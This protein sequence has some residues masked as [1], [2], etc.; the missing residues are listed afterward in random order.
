MRDLKVAW[1]GGERIFQNGELI[2]TENSHKYTVDSIHELLRS[3]GFTKFNNWTDP[4][5]Y[6]AVIYAQ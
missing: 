1:P 5:N 6:F 3:A 2:H 4:E